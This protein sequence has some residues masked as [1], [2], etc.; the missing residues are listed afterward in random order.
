MAV[1]TSA[2]P[3]QHI[4]GELPWNGY[5]LQHP[6]LA[7]FTQGFGRTHLLNKN[8]VYYEQMNK[9]RIN[10]ALKQSPDIASLGWDLLGLLWK[11]VPGNSVIPLLH[12]TL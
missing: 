8:T 10:E 9:N 1:G 3:S 5:G 6:L 12:S 11:G 4:K 2:T 7:A